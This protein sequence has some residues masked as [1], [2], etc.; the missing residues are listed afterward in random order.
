MTDMLCLCGRIYK[1]KFTESNYKE[2]DWLAKAIQWYRKGFE[3][4]PNIYAGINLATLLVVHGDQF[5]KSRELQTISKERDVC[6]L[7]REMKSLLL[8]N[9]LHNLLGRKGSLERLS[10]YW[11]VATYFEISV[12]SDDYGKACAAA[13]CMFKL[14]PQPW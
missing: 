8:V 3:V 6:I 4:Q 2:K 1:D 13:E 9:T 11:D 12:L 14:N 7:F 5:S 10:D